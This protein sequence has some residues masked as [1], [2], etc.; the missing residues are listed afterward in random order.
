MVGNLQGEDLDQY[1]NIRSRE[2]K[3][4]PE[5]ASADEVGKGDWAFRQ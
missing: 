3:S 5:K 4:S 2:T 1:K